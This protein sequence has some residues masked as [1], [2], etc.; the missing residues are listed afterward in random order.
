[1]GEYH[2]LI[3]EMRLFDHSSF[4]KYFH[5]SPAKFDELLS[6][7]GPIISKRVTRMRE[8]ISPG[9]R[10]AVTLRFLVTGDYMQTISLSFCLGHSLLAILLKVLVMHYGKY[11]PLSLCVCLK[12]MKNGRES[13]MVLR[14]YGIFHTV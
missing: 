8:S 7:V 12:V 13:V 6:R 9:E 5:M 1:M 14:V 10:L 3:Q 11:F 4:Y 2:A